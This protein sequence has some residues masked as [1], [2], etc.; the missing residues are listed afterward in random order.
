MT[1]QELQQ[2]M[3]KDNLH[4]KGDLLMDVNENSVYNPW[5]LTW[6]P[7][8]DVGI[9]FDQYHTETGVYL[10]LVEAC[11]ARLMK[12]QEHPDRYYH[13]EWSNMPDE[14]RYID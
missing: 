5:V 2:W 1:E 9:P 3:E 10:S 4:F 14:R 12:M 11:D 6:C 13:V 7:M 8:C